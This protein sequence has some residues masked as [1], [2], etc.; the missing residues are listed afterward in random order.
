MRPMMDQGGCA[1]KPGCRSGSA[2]ERGVRPHSGRL[3]YVAPKYKGESRNWATAATGQAAR[4][5]P[6]SP[7]QPVSNWYHSRSTYLSQRTATISPRRKNRG[8]L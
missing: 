6:V 5:T 2:L 4:Q 1:A 8:V 7:A 3:G